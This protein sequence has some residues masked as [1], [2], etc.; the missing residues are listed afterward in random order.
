MPLPEGSERSPT[1]ETMTPNPGPT[2]TA[3]LS[4]TPPPGSA[5][6][7]VSLGTNCRTG[8]GRAYKKVGALL[9]NETV[10][11]LAGEPA[12]HFWYIQNPDHAGEYCW[13]TGQYATVS[14]NTSA[15]PV[16]TPPPTITPDP[17][18]TPDTLR[19][20]QAGGSSMVE[21]IFESPDTGAK[22]VG[23]VHDGELVRLL[24]EPLNPR[25]R[26]YLRAGEFNYIETAGGL[27]G[28]VRDYSSKGP[29][30]FPILVP[31]EE[32][33]PQAERKVG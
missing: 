11:V 19:K 16:Y 33:E 22:V 15:L 24:P 4:A 29:E 7:S 12:G 13:V 14:D 18:G 23:Y 3:T 31:P 26:R 2:S 8:P 20:V 27:Q 28:W 17:S 25:G 6:I 9:V 30:G 32:W 5:L 21:K 10:Q 1:A